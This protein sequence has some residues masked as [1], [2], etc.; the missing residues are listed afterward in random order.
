MLRKTIPLIFLFILIPFTS[1][2]CDDDASSEKV[3]SPCDETTDCDGVCNTAVPGGMCI[4]PCSDVDLCGSG[5]NCLPFSDTESYCVPTCTTVDDCRDGY[6]CANGMC[7]P[8]VPLGGICE[9]TEDCEA[10]ETQ[11]SCPEGKTVECNE[12]ICSIPCSQMDECPSTTYCGLSG[13]AYWC[14]AVDFEQGENTFGDS[15]AQGTCADDFTCLE[16]GTD[17]ILSYCSKECTVD[18]DCPPSMRCADNGS[19]SNWCLKRKNCDT[20]NMDGQCGFQTDRCV[21]ADPAKADA[22]YCSV[23]CDP[24]RAGTCPVDYSCMQGYFCED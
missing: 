23:A 5:T 10:C 4:K 14:V 19:G 16:M 22:T 11:T 9:E 24:D 17:N 12:G 2:S 13:D 18:R 7:R 8:P 21:T 1:I 6:V 20:C 15:C 3:G